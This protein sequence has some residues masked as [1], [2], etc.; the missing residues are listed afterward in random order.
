VTLP[1]ASAPDNS[2]SAVVSHHESDRAS[3][4]TVAYT[5]NAQ[6]TFKTGDKAAE[7]TARKIV[8]TIHG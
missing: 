7:A 8:E 1:S 6:V 5:C 2:A 3:L 4:K